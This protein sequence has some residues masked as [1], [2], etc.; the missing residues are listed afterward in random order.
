MFKE[1]RTSSFFF[2]IQSLSL[3]TRQGMILEHIYGLK[4]CGNYVCEF[5]LGA[6]G[7]KDFAI[8]TAPGRKDRRDFQSSWEFPV[9]DF[10]TSWVGSS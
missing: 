1:I 6:I 9:Y 2:E 4:E 10:P 3:R 8:K 7:K 5:K